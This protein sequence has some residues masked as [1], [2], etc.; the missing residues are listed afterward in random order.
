VLHRLNEWY[1]R[2]QSVLESKRQF[3]A[4][5]SGEKS[6]EAQDWG[7]GYRDSGW[8]YM[9][10]A[11]VT[12]T[13]QP[14]DS[15]LSLIKAMKFNVEADAEPMGNPG[16]PGYRVALRLHGDQKGVIRV[17]LM[18]WMRFLVPA[19]YRKRKRG[20]SEHI[21]HD[22]LRRQVAKAGRCLKRS[23]EALLKVEKQLADLSAQ[24]QKKEHP[25]AAHELEA[26]SCQIRQRRLRLRGKLAYWLLHLGCDY[27]NRPFRLFG[28]CLLI[29][30]FF[31]YLYH[32]AGLATCSVDRLFSVHFTKWPYVANRF[33]N[34]ITAIY[35]SVVTFVTLGY[36]DI[37]PDN[38]LGRGLAMVEAALGFT[39]FG[40]FVAVASARL[41]PR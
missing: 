29:V 6:A 7:A 35:F 15:L 21:W 1:Q 38:P 2:V 34:I 12:W 20:Y 33:H 40:L 37:T 39:M 41:R 5:D 16:D 17:H 19:K 26:R 13:R 11:E 9:L 18:H 23:P 27:G 14:V 24:L 4:P 3:G 31:A 30:V 22:V 28:W 32:P 36:G 8:F 10:R 25:T